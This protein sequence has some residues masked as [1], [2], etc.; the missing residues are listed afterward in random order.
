MASTV[1]SASWCWFA[2]CAQHPADATATATVRTADGV[3]LGTLAAW[4]SDADPP[5][6]ASKIDARAIDPHGEEAIAS[7]VLAP[8]G[9]WLPFDDPAV[10]H[11]IRAVL[12]LCPPDAFST[13]LRDDFRFV[14][15]ITAMRGS[16]R[17]LD[18]D[19]FARVL[20]GRRVHIGPGLVGWTLPPAGPTMQRHGSASPWP[21]G[22]FPS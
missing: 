15:A 4:E 8:D 18:D 10:S 1:R 21:A 5:P 2:L 20:P 3:F 13:L 6:T 12:Q 16:T 7:L 9:L 14:G 11:A 19:P 17:R 22:A